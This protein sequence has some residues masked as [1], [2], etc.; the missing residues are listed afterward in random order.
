[1]PKLNV[2]GCDIC[3]RSTELCLQELRRRG[4][5]ADWPEWRMPRTYCLTPAGAQHAARLRHDNPRPAQRQAWRAMRHRYH[6][7]HDVEANGFF[8]AL[9]AGARDLPDRG[10]YRWLGEASCRAA[11]EFDGSPAS[12]GWGQY[13]LPDRE[14]TFDLECDRGTEHG[15]RIRR[16]ASGYVNYFRG[17]REAEL[18]H[19]L[20]VAPTRMREGELHDLIEPVVEGFDNLCRFWTTA[21]ETTAAVGWS[22]KAWLE[23]GGSTRRV[24][25]ADLAGHPRS[26]RSTKSQF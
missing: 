12:D 10:L 26:A 11:Y 21:I 2:N 19:V 23:I 16:K 14:I 25:F 6:M 17:R 22:G 5:A 1:M 9:A 4:L 20:W 7:R 8:V 15:Q 18:H 3:R 13:L 24:A